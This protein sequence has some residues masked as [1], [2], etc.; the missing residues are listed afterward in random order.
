MLL[1]DVVIDVGGTTYAINGTARAGVK[2]GVYRDAEEIQSR[3][4]DANGLLKYPLTPLLD[5]GLKMCPG[6]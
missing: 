3:E 1:M 6:G 4:L 2:A 5:A